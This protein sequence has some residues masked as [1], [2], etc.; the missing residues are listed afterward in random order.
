MEKIIKG[1]DYIGITVCFYCH[2]N[3]GNMLLQKRS[4]ACRDE[5]GT[6]DCGGGSMEFGETF[7][8]AVRRELKEEYGATPKSIRFCGVNNVLRK[9]RSKNTHWIAII[10]DVVVD[11][12]QIVNNNP[13][14]IESL[15]WFTAEA[16]PQPL[17]SMYLRHWLV[18]REKRNSR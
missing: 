2:D 9:N 8:D 3:N 12:K 1:V 6:W 14:R 5:Q 18:V 13:E 15:G 11:P 4:S 16:L 7:E 17:H 10:F